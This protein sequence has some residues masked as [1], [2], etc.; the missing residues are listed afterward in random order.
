M[1]AIAVIIYRCIINQRLRKRICKTEEESP[2]HHDESE[3]EP[4]DKREPAPPLDETDSCPDTSREERPRSLT[5]DSGYSASIRSDSIPLAERD[6]QT[7]V[8]V[9]NSK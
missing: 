2:L 4:E 7:P 1:A 8:T 9:N 6:K 3:M 5:D